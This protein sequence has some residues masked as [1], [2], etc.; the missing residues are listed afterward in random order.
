MRRSFLRFLRCPSCCSDS[1][2]IYAEQSRGDETLEGSILCEA[3]SAG[4][5]IRGGVPRFVS[6]DS[7][8]SAFS[9]EWKAHPTLQLDPK[10]RTEDTLYEK[11][12]LTPQD[13]RGK[14]VLEAGCGTGRF[15]AVIADQAQEV[16]AFDL[17][18]SVD[19]AQEI[20]GSAG[21]VHIAQADI[22]RLPFRTGL[23]DLA[24]SIGVLPFTPDPAKAF[25][26]LPPL[27]KTGGIVAAYVFS[28]MDRTEFLLPDVWRRITTRLPQPLLYELCRR[29]AEPLYRL[30]TATRLAPVL[31]RLFVANL[32]DDPEARIL[33]MFNWYAPKYLFR[34]DY[35]EVYRW[36]R[37]AGIESVTLAPRPLGMNG[38]KGRAGGD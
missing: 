14:V 23:F 32:D 34:F 28:G 30:Y 13:F 4:Y 17:S 21:N 1:L 8:T 3:C 18:E 25:A 19:V 9:L 27:V 22:F 20:L 12:G 11:L 10:F 15:S 6:T 2:A 24:F 36:F 5:P 38:V 7:Y 35:P 16:V 33:G 37:D 31:N 26:A 29:A